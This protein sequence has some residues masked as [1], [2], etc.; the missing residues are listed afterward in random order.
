MGVDTLS[1]QGAPA[2]CACTS[3]LLVL[4]GWQSIVNQFLLFTLM[5]SRRPADSR[6]VHAAPAAIV[7]I[8]EEAQVQREA[9]Q[10]RRNG[11]P[12]QQQQEFGNAGG[13][14]EEPPRE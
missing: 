1:A 14:E 3:T 8:S 6:D 10:E 4:F 11:P 5:F 2:R 12:M 13:E 9:E 7:Y